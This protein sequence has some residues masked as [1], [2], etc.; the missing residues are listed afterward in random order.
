MERASSNRGTGAAAAAGAGAESVSLG[1]VVNSLV[2]SINTHR[3]ATGQETFQSDTVQFDEILNAVLETLNMNDL[4]TIVGGNWQPL[5]RA[6]IPLRQHILHKLLKDDSSPQSKAKAVSGL[7]AALIQS[8]ENSERVRTEAEA[9]RA[10]SGRSL[11]EISAEVFNRHFA[12]L[13]EIALNEQ[14]SEND[15]VSDFRAWTFNFAGDWV[16]SLITKGG[17][18]AATVRRLATTIVAVGL[19][20]LGPEYQML[21]MMGSNLMV[22][23]LMKTYTK[24]A[25]TGALPVKTTLPPPS[26][27]SSASSS[28][29]SSSTSS[30]SA[31]TTTTAAVAVPTIS[32]GESVPSTSSIAA[33][34]QETEDSLD[35]WLAGLSPEERR[36]L[37]Q[38][39]ERDTVL[40]Q[41]W[42][43][44]P[45]DGF[46]SAYCNTTK[47]S[48]PSTDRRS[49]SD[50]S[51][52]VSASATTS[53]LDSV[54]KESNSTPSYPT[55]SSS[56]ETEDAL[57]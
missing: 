34:Q 38:T 9:C 19:S 27:S 56:S 5:E 11:I 22:E 3:T 28:S 42:M 2:D 12:L 49:E 18:D 13:I 6:Q 55:P 57:D 47:P 48:T 7:V 50:L 4:L 30:E 33:P 36:D 15:F 21:S 45:A 24:Y 25:Q 41:N 51:S 14:L 40:Q 37:Q 35:P 43:G 53:N 26:A 10:V 29:S 46:S 8:M 32:N 52:P 23:H 31:T 1:S 44:P 39:I 20:A 16:D 54:P 17:I